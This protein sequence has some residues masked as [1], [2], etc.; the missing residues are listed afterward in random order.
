MR[1]ANIN[2]LEFSEE[3]SQFKNCVDECENTILID[4]INS[5]EGI[6]LE[7][8]KLK[9]LGY[10]QGE[11][12]EKL[13]MSQGTISRKLVNILNKYKLESGERDYE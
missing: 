3:I 2:T 9:Y 13:N 4:I 12:A 5:T 7:I 1:K 11:I 8:I 6:D 10:N